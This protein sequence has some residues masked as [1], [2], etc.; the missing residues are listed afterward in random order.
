MNRQMDPTVE[1]LFLTP[2]ENLTYISSSFVREIAQMNG[3]VGKFVPEA[4][5]KALNKKFRE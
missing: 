5:V 4:V 1:S 3:D 2:A